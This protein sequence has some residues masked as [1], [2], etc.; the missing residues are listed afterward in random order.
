MQTEINIAL[1]KN[2]D[3]IPSNLGG[4]LVSVGGQAGRQAV[5]QKILQFDNFKSVSSKA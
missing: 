1:G 3:Y 4:R 5:R 2:E